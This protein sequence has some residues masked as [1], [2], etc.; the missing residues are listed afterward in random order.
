[1]TATQIQADTE[2]YRKSL[3]LGSVKETKGMD[4]VQL[5]YYKSYAEFFKN[6]EKDLAAVLSSV[7]KGLEERTSQAKRKK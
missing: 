2:R 7:V 3:G 1:M 5:I 4:V 6:L